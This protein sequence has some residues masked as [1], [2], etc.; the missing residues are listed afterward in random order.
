MED[1]GSILD[2]AIFRHLSE[3]VSALER[4]FEA[5]L[6]YYYG[7]T[8]PAFLKN[9]RDL[10]ENLVDDSNKRPRLVIFLRSEGGL[11]E[12]VEKM[13]EMIRTHYEEVYFV[14]PD[15]A[16]SAAT[17]FCMSGDKIFMD[18]SSSLGPI[19]PQLQI[20]TDSGD[21][22]VPVLGYLDQVE[23]LIKKSAD[24]TL[25][26]AEY[27]LIQNQDLAMLSSYEQARELSIDLL[28]KW[29]VEW[30]FKNWTAHR[31][32]LSKQ[33]QTVTESEKE[34][35]AAE[36]A[37]KLGDHKFWHSHGRMI[38]V[39]TLH[40]ILRLE[41]DD[42]TNDVPRRRLIRDYNDSLTDYFERQRYGF[43]LHSRIQTVKF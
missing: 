27:G 26:P 16:M 5:D 36:I 21:R 31:T 30:K 37:A 22:Y 41:I 18:Y 4:H 10:L 24:G 23:R 13:V 39:S 15:F 34:I 40:K 19:D 17:I 3:A 20:K 2:Q 38:G 35:R 11:V 28:K 43:C 9:F 33:H 25:T 12:P 7:V 42:Y 1:K 29:L 14:V 6:V 32:D 8:H